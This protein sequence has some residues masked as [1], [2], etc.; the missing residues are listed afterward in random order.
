LA[1]DAPRRETRMT[2]EATDAVNG[3]VSLTIY[4]DF[5]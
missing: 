4:S 2:Q 1:S 3:P 5:V